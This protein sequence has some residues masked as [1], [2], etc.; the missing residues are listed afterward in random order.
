[1]AYAYEFNQTVDTCMQS[2]ESMLE[3]GRS[4]ANQQVSQHAMFGHSVPQMLYLTKLLGYIRIM[5]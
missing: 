4:I 2:R 5:C 3:L 1:M